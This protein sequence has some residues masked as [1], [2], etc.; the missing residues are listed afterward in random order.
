LFYFGKQQ[1]ELHYSAKLQDGII[2][3]VL[4]ILLVQ[5]EWE[6]KISAFITIQL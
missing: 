6:Q 4:I 1:T 5:Q 2:T 3:R